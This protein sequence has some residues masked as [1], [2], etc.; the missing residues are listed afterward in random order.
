MA[1]CHQSG[2]GDGRM[3]DDVYA[4][5]VLLLTLALGR[6]PLD[7]SDDATIMF[8]KL[9]VGDFAAMAGNERLPP[10]LGDLIR[11]MVAEDPDHRPTP[12]A[13]RDPAAARSRRVVGRPPVHAQRSFRLGAATVW[14]T[15]GLALAM[16]LE[17]DEA[18]AALHSG[19]LTYWLR[20]GLGDSGL[21]VKMEELVRQSGQDLTADKETA[22]AALVMRAIADADLLMPLC[23]QGLAMFPDGLGPL[24]ATDP[25]TDPGLHQKLLT[26]VA[27]EAHGTW[28]GMRE[29]R[30]PSAPQKLEARQRRAIQ[31]IKGP[32][33]GMPRLSYTLNPQSPCISK[34]LE[35]RWIANVRDLAPALNA[36]AAANPD[37]DLLE[38]QIAAF[39]GARSERQLDQEV[40]FLTTDGDAAA[41]AL[42]ALQL[43]SELQARFHPL[44]LTGLTT[45][46][47]ARA[48]PLVERWQNRER[49]AAVDAQLK[50]L[51]EA[52]MLRPIL[53]LLEDQPG[54]AMDSEGL[55]A[56]LAELAHLDAELLGIARGG[57]DRA[58]LA[59]RL[60]QEVAAGIGLFAVALTLIL[61]ALG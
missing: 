42:T 32:A 58:A 34:L 38:P 36:V 35:G 21:A 12:A 10:M 56:A 4:L 61:A 6:Q 17:P 39:I 28:A 11:I 22:Q 24:L 15:R 54:H 3:A 50:T 13:L 48:K 1:V 2:R 18:A 14:N 19:T 57:A 37:A 23:W 44:P 59:A 33:G 9:E 30:A 8:R 20:R 29:E 60:G 5:G 45:W 26:I 51:V 49:R 43:L 25:D 47:A 40:K 53:T 31:Q 7:G 27:T 52:G 46:V 41:R 16:A 55:R